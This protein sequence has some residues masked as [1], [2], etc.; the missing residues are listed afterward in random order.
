MKVHN[1]TVV[2]TGGG[3]GIGREIVL[4][5]L[6]KRARVAVVDIDEAGLKVA[7]D[8]AGDLQDRL[9]N[10]IVNI[11]DRGAVFLLPE[12]AAKIIFPKCA[13]SCRINL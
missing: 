12:R 9:S 8:L 4:L 1:K 10:H 3:N 13:R 11:S 7:T 2:V 6:K 5:L